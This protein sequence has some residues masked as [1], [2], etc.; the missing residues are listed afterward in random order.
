[1][2]RRLNIDPQEVDDSS[3]LKRL[4]TLV[5]MYIA[6][7]AER[8]V[9]SQQNKVT[10]FVSRIN[11]VSRKPPPNLS[12][13][14]SRF[15]FKLEAT[16]QTEVPIITPIPEEKEEIKDNT[17]LPPVERPKFVRDIPANIDYVL[18]Q[19]MRKNELINE[20]ILPENANRRHPD[21][22]GKITFLPQL[23]EIPKV[24]F[25]ESSNLK[26]PEKKGGAIVPKGAS[27]L[28]VDQ[29]EA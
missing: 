17:Q 24:K 16:P 6:K 29:A 4:M 26:S 19:R 18:E 14:S 23:P 7:E 22:P 3:I 13:A 10:D 1:M 8:R 15:T 12:K 11:E 5:D 25:Y 28:F 27:K 21:P 20:N 2:E 9:S